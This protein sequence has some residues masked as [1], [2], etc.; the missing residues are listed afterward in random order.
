MKNMEK[1]KSELKKQINEEIDKYYEEITNGI[2]NK[3]LKIEEIERL[4]QEK[5]S[6]LSK[7]LLESTGKAVSE[8]E[9]KKKTV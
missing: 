9:T 3:N 4:L 2:K 7:M 1:E 6:S 8:D 5:K